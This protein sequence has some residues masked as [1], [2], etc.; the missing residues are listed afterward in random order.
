MALIA[1]PGVWGELGGPRGLEGLGGGSAFLRGCP[2]RGR[3]H[4]K[5]ETTPD[6]SKITTK[7]KNRSF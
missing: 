7:T 3:D 6:H 1:G 5:L 2:G 4:Q